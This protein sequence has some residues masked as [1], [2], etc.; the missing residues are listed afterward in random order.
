ML[1]R[2]LRVR[3]GVASGVLAASEEA[4]ASKVLDTSRGRWGWCG[5]QG[6]GAG[7][8]RAAACLERGAARKACVLAALL[9]RR[10]SWHND[11]GA[12]RWG[13]LIFDYT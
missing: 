2:G 6:A 1:F 3:I 9:R 10:C 7:R 13:L 5:S 8:W 4:H 11:A 12:G